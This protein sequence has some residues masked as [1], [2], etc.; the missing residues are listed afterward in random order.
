M[1]ET[2]LELTEAQR[3]FEDVVHRLVAQLREL[4]RRLRPAPRLFAQPDYDDDPAPAPPRM[5]VDYFDD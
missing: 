2:D 1:S 5:M 4:H 3:K